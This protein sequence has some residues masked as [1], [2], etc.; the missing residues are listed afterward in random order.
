MKYCANGICDSRLR[1]SV[2]VP[3]KL[4]IGDVVKLPKGVVDEK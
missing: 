3:K 1:L 4:K 2:N